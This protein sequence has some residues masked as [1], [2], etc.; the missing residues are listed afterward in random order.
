MVLSYE[1]GLMMCFRWFELRNGVGV[2][3]VRVTF[4]FQPV[5]M[6][7]PDHLL[8]YGMTSFPHFLNPIIN[9]TTIDRNRSPHNQQCH[10]AQF[11]PR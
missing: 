3:K 6:R 7:E 11:P 5:M 2:G 4:M 9:K 10:A 8:G 1:T